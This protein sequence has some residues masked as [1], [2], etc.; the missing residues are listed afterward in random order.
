MG[1]Q[2]VFK[3]SE[4][5]LCLELNVRRIGSGAFQD[6]SKWW[7]CGL[8]ADY[9]FFTTL[10]SYF[11]FYGIPN[12]AKVTHLRD[13]FLTLQGSFFKAKVAST[14]AILISLHL[15]KERFSQCFIKP[16]ILLAF[17][18]Q[19]FIVSIYPRRWGQSKSDQQ[20]LICWPFHTYTDQKM[21]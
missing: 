19:C 15:K 10:K 3:I 14:A 5:I 2:S 18:G 21:R 1:I 13:L 9:Y 17:D 7:F 6:T 20:C 12:F 8:K 16:V 11:T 4:Y